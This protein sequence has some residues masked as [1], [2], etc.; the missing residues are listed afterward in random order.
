MAAD[1]LREVLGNMA[2]AK[3][4]CIHCGASM[5][6]HRHNISIAMVRGLSLLAQFDE[7]I[8][9]KILGLTR[10]QWDN[11][12][13]LRYWD[14]VKKS[15]DVEGNRRGGHWECTVKGRDFLA[16]KIKVPKALWTYRGAFI[17]EEKEMVYVFEIDQGYKIRD[18]YA[19][20]AVASEQLG[21]F[22]GEEFHE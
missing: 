14:L 21:L 10:N 7:A 16:G 11:F 19:A 3:K 12:Q 2:N 1:F 20:E 5:L 9:I 8:N 22:R 17:R 6:E 4:H 15:Y 13:K 18:E